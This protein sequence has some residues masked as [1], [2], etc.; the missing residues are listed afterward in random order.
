MTVEV[1]SS[2]GTSAYQSTRYSATV[3]GLSA[4]VYG[5]S[6]VAV[7]P[8]QL[9]SAGATVEPAWFQFGANETATVVVTKLSGPITSAK[10]YPADKGVTYTVAGGVL[11]L[12][13]PQNVRIWIE[14]NA[15]RVPLLIQSRPLKPALPVSRTDWSTLGK[16]VSSIDTGTNVL[17]FG[18]A[19][20]LT[21]GQ[22]VVFSTT[23]T[24]PTVTGTAL[25]VVEPV[26]VLATPT[27]TTLT[28][29]RTQGGAAIDF[30]GTGTGSLR[31]YPGE[32]TNTSSA[33][34]FPAGVHVVGRL[35]K[36]GTGV[37]CYI[38]G[39]AVLFATSFDLRGSQ[40]I[41]IQGAG[42][43]FCNYEVW[44]NVVGL[45]YTEQVLYAPFCGYD[46]VTFGY[47]NT[48]SGIMLAAWPFFFAREGVAH[49]ENV[50]G[51]SPWNY[52]NDGFDCSVTLDGSESTVDH[53]MMFCAD[54]TIYLESNWF[55]LHATDLF[56]VN[57]NGGTF[58]FGYWGEENLGKFQKLTDCDA[59]SIVLDDEALALPESAIGGNAIIKLWND[60][61]ESEAAAGFGRFNIQIRGLKVW[62]GRFDNQLLSIDNQLY[63]FG[64]SLIRDGLGDVADILIED[65]W[66]EATPGQI[67]NIT[68]A[69][70]AN[71]PHDI[72]FV[73]CEIGGV[74]LRPWNFFEFFEVNAYP[75][76]ITVEGQTVV[77]AVELCNRALAYVGESPFVTSISPPDDTKA[78]KLCQKFWPHVLEEVT[79][80]HEW[81]WATKRI[82][83][84]E[85]VDGG[86]DFWRY[87]YEEPAGML[88]AIE[89]L[90]KG[91]PDGF[92]DQSG[93]RV[94]FR[95]EVDA[96]GVPRLWSNLPEAWLR[97]SVYVTDPNLLDPWAQ[98]AC[99]MLLA[100][101]LAGAIM[102]GRE[103]Q[104][105][106]AQFGQMA[107]ASIAR[108]KANDGNQRILTPTEGQ[109]VTWLAGRV[110]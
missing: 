96:D 62:G 34:Y 30:T 24:L 108:A 60:N 63:P 109:S 83:L 5:Y 9:W 72:Q 80:G 67:S 56:G 22:R 98:D 110:S 44:A 51:V 17:T 55:T 31:L 1:Y 76:N 11:T 58:L 77:T 84:T 14:C 16:L 36:L 32:W 65:L 47:S 38:D 37:T 20:G 13:V 8:T 18:S 106:M 93:N 66:V 29:S 105:A 48:V 97:Y 53:C 26:Y 59:M 10:V 103:G 70:W 49:W 99:V 39:G 85:V 52:N 50:L 64:D 87:C 43:V 90:P 42:Q 21:A 94:Q 82:E 68:G 15:D 3:N 89:M 71:T 7:M 28:L 102:Q 107:M 33:L 92:R 35:L 25:A 91:A 75:Y 6:R 101:K 12:Q 40:G 86:N 79:Q 23:G 41:T 61:R 45:P 27:S 100:S 78:A 73:R 81:G 95:R 88:R 4:Y 19:H 57:A 104:Q 46:G 54:D 69:N 2:P 74:A